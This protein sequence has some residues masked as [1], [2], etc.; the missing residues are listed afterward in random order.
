MQFKPIKQL[1]AILT[2]EYFEPT[3]SWAFRVVLAL[4]VPMILLP[5]W[6]GF[7]YEVIWAAFGAYL[8]SLTDYRGLHYKKIMIQSLEAVL[9]F[10]AGMLG[11]LVASSVWLSV[12][13]MF[14]VGLFAA[15]I[16]NWSDYGSSIGVAVG[17]FFLF[18][19][20]NPQPL[21]QALLYGLYLL[22]GAGWAIFITLLSFPLR[23]SNPVKRSVAR[24]WKANTELLDAII[25]ERSSDG[26]NLSANIAGKEM[27]L[28]TAINQSVNLFERREKSSKVQHYDILIELRRVAALFGGALSSIHE[29]LEEIK[30]TDLEELREATL[31][32][33]LSSIA[34]AS[35]R[36]SIVIYTSRPEDLTLAKV[37]TQRVGIAIDLF[38][39][40]LKS[41][42]KE[43]R[44]KIAWTHFTDS[45][46]K[47]YEYINQSLSLLDQKLE[48]RKGDY[49][50]AYKLTYNNFVAGVK[51]W[52][53]VDFLK[54]LVNI[55]SEQFR[56]A[57]RVALVLCFGVF[58]F[59][60]FEMSHGYWIPLTIIIV[61]QPYYGATRK[62]GLER[63]IGTV[64]GIV[65]GG[66]IMMLPLSHWTFVVL[67]V[68]VSFFV[69]YFLRNNYKVGVFF[70]TVMMVIMMQLSQ[71]ASWDLIGWRVL[72]TLI[73]AALALLAGYV[74]WPVWEIQRFP[75]LMS[76]AIKQTQ[77][78]L[79]RVLMFY[80]RELPAGESWYRQRRI[81]EEANN[82]AFACVQRMLEEPQKRQQQ[83]DECF[84]MVGISIR[85][86]REITSIALLAEKNKSTETL[87]ALREYREKANELFE[88]EIVRIKNM[89]ESAG[90]GF[91]E[92]KSSLIALQSGQ[93]KDLHVIKTELGK[94]VFELE[95]LRRISFQTEIK[96]F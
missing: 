8:I 93:Q 81:A 32:K 76:N 3:V 29:E 21:D 55:N 56:Y 35:A 10:C 85:I 39:E 42:E 6:K 91:S 51:S 77:F 34:Q 33:T 92:I 30:R 70:V 95:A 69:A 65:L 84:S 45:L 41:W 19:L 50:E 75:T 64:L 78:Y 44:E 96:P 36:L 37:R 7:S 89:A 83:L 68:I 94:I 17:F 1:N 62:K 43:E 12:V 86:A 13:A 82:N 16:R 90:P 14:F 4:N 28:R 73:G 54:N 27:V 20:A 74:F 88:H 57:L 24:I 66:V 47:A 48:L 59:R 52:V 22:I 79:D 23:P 49:F 53:I 87:V 25:E 5:L 72:A 40:E 80:N 2:Q 26:K 60:F 9:I 71:Q 15:F 61:I 67:L 31:Y 38:K 63:I 18:G 58:L 11:M 46:D